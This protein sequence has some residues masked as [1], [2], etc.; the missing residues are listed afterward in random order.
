MQNRNIGNLNVSAVG[1]GCMGL[2]HAFGTATDKETAIGVLRSAFD[3]GYTFFDTAECYIGVNSDGSV[4][5]NEEIVG[6]ALKP[7]RN[8]VVI[9]T[10]FGVKHGEHGLIMNSRSETIR[11]SVEGSLIRLQT[12]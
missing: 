12:D 8:Q 10:K 2:S 4:S 11:K 5:N 3:I 1:F 9:A 7:I 6:E